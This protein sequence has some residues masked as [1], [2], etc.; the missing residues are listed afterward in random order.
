MP[1]SGNFFFVRSTKLKPSEVVLLD[2]KPLWNVSVATFARIDEICGEGASRIFAEPNVKN[3][4]DGGTVNVAW[5]G[6]YDDDPRELGMVDRA[7]LLRVEEDLTQKLAA[8][9]PALLDSEIGGRVAA[10]LNLF[11]QN[12]IM[13]VGEHAVLTNWGALPHDAMA[14]QAGY[15][16]HVGAT[17]GRFLRADMSPGLPGRAW[18]ATG[19][20]ETVP[21]P[22]RREDPIQSKSAAR[23]VPTGAVSPVSLRSGKWWIPASLIALFGAI[24]TYVCWPG[25]L[26]YEKEGPPEAGILSQ[27]ASTNEALAKDIAT[28]KREVSKDS[29]ELDPTLVG[30]PP[31]DATSLQSPADAGT[32]VAK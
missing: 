18:A 3:Q 8:L 16:H 27:L 28:L 7:K 6:S 15:S 17:I 24:L 30:L 2:G 29:C 4:D 25:N 20:I 22:Q 10:M 32:G 26:V 5:F 14:S 12:S 11:D 1:G 21:Q 9:R 19:G 23:L 13:A 31:R